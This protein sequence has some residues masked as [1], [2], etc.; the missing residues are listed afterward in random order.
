VSF[1]GRRT[2]VLM[3]CLVTTLLVLLK[4]GPTK[5]KKATDVEFSLD[6]SSLSL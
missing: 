2:A 5:G 3:L 6:V 4:V 1:V